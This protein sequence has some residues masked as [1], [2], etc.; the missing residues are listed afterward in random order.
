M[1]AIRY[2]ALSALVVWLGGMIVLG[3]LVAPATFGVMQGAAS[4]AATGRMLA[5]AVFGEILRR[6]HIL[7]YGCGAILLACLFVMKFVGPP[8]QAFVARIAIVAI[9]LA[10][11]LYSGI[12]VSREINQIQSQVSGPI[13]ALPQTDAR[14]SR[15]DRLHGLST[16]LMTINMGLGLVLLYWY[17]RE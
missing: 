2:V 6:F 9:M 16:T 13:S 5:G 15:F 7:A 8:P 11:A 14:R 4:D 3:L 17:V 10:I 1:L 12:L